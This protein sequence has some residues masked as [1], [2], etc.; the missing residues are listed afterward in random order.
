MGYQKESLY[1]TTLPTL[2]VSKS[3]FQELESECPQIGFG[4]EGGIYRYDDRYAIKIFEFFEDEEKLLQKYK[5]IERL[6]EL[7]DPAF[8]TPIGLFGYETALKEGYYMDLVHPHHTY[9]D[10][11]AL[12]WKLHRLRIAKEALS[13]IIKADAAIQRIHKQG[14]IIGDIRGDNIMIDDNGNPRFVDVDN[15]VYDGFD[16]DLEPTRSKWMRVV[17]GREASLIDNDKYVFAILAFEI[18]FPQYPFA[19]CQ[20]GTFYKRFI[21][22][23]NASKEAK[24]GLE[25]LLSDAADKPYLGEVLA[26]IN[27]DEELFS[28]ED[29]YWLKQ[30][31]R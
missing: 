30:L 29:H 31:I 1:D 11:D 2:I 4:Q 18:L 22:C 27:F 20:G 19:M 9:R 7:Q 10:F 26:N 8:C 13:Y 17:F 25:I 15:Y 12:A 14:A 6:A 23:I 3:K 16:F 24:E 5:K 21:K 28:E